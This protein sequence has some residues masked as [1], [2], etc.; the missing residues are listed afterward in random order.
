MIPLMVLM[1]MVVSGFLMCM[2]AFMIEVKRQAE[3]DPE[4]SA[5]LADLKESLWK[6]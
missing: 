3:T 6:L 4:Q 5:K 1:A 2:V